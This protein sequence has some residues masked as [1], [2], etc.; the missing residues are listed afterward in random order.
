[1]GSNNS[2]A[3]SGTASRV[4]F[5]FLSWLSEKQ[6]FVFIVST[7][8]NIIDLPPEI[9]RK[10]RFDE[11]FFINLPNSIERRHIFK[12]HLIHVRPLTWFNY[13]IDLLSKIAVNFSGSEIRQ[14]IIETMHN[15]FCEKREFSI[16][17]IVNVIQSFVPLYLTCQANIANLQQWAD[18]GKVSLASDY[19]DEFLLD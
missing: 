8:N 1:M 11:I 3:D 9:L 2:Y 12:I 6:S 18:C 7:A 19:S 16:L 5:T 15:A 17:D 10:G 14:V 13:D 4:F